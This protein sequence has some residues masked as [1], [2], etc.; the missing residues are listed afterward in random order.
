LLR[1]QT[2]SDHDALE[3]S[4]P[5]IV[6]EAEHAIPARGKPLIASFIVAKTGFE[7][8]TFAIDLCDKFAGVRDEVGDV[9]P[10]GAL[11]A[12]SEP[13][14][15]VCLQMTPQRGFSARHFPS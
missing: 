3:I 15:P 8:V 9:I 14:Q 5:I 1:S 13:G 7:I 4:H 11:S 12:K 10:H 2:D 6:G